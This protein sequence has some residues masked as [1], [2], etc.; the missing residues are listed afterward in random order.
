MENM[1][2]FLLDDITTRSVRERRELGEERGAEQ[3]N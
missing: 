2:I 3:L 1:R